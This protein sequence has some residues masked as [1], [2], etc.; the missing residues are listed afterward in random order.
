MG[1]RPHVVPLLFF[2]LTIA[3]RLDAAQSFV[4]LVPACAAC[5]TADVDAYDAD[6]GRLAAEIPI[7]AH[8]STAQLA[9]SLDG[10]RLYVSTS[11]ADG[12]KLITVIDTTRHTVVGS[13]AVAQSGN[14]AVSRDGA[15]L[16]IA[17]GSTISVYD[18]A[19][20]SIVSTTQ[21]PGF[22]F[23]IAASPTADRIYTAEQAVVGSAIG[24]Y[25]SITG[26]AVP[27]APQDVGVLWTDVHVSRDG[28]R[29][30]ATF[31]TRPAHP[32][33][34]GGVSIF[35]PSDWTRTDVSN[36]LFPAGTI[37]ARNGTRLYSWE[38][39]RVTAGGVLQLPPSVTSMTVSADETRGWVTA[40]ALS[41]RPDSAN[42]IHFLNLDTFSLMR[43]I[44]LAGA[45]SN[46]AATLPNAAVC[47][48]QVDTAQ[49]SW[50]IDGGS[51]TIAVKTPCAWSA[52]SDS[53]WA[54]IAPAQGM[55][56][57]PLTLTVD[58]NSSAAT[59]TATIS[60][61]GRVVTVTEAG[62]QSA[63]PIGFVD[64]P[65]D[66]ITGVSGALA[67]GG[68]ALDDVGVSRVMIF[69]DPVAGETPG[70]SIFIGDAKFVDGARPDVQA[71]FPGVPFASRAGWGAL[72]LTNFLPNQGNGTFHLLIY[73]LDLEG[74]L[75]LLGRR[76]IT[77]AN[78][79]AT[80]PFGSIDTPVAG[81]TVSGTIVNFGWVLTPQPKRIVD[82]SAIDVL[83]DGAVVGHPSYGFAR[84]DIQSAFP[85]Y[86]NTDG[87][88]G[89]FML[90]TTTLANG[91][92]TIAWIA[93]DSAGAAQGLGAR[94]FI[95]S[96]P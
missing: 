89:F 29:L 62:T 14:L 66:N 60:I 43:T 78:A 21:A 2:I 91:L 74:H 7:T 26:T 19:M 8:V 77:V 44:A 28:T 55:G 59:R 35:N 76:T 15:H 64:T 42:A 46:P 67:L 10:Q 58:P 84:S 5:A 40:I 56:D 36:G 13:H 34:G 83:V 41:G 24:Q 37:D 93:R 1:H 49:S 45:P 71:A 32:G 18:T 11:H 72:V 50:T 25:D 57:T 53:S 75:A 31:P 12:T 82:G 17:G 86:A 73:A 68:W 87:A 4:Y 88:V 94:F 6:T 79:T 65:A 95:V 80:L 48:Y 23:A 51:A 52:V 92:H 16:F 47:S 81:G 30:Y 63:A 22:V 38:G 69:R 96:N 85:G 39:D 61:G 9:L 70:Q 54:R 33:N 3:A 90:D 27:G 20:N